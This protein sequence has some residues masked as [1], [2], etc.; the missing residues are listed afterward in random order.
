MKVCPN[1]K[2]SIRGDWTT[3]P[4]C[5][6]P[7]TNTT[8]EIKETTSVFLEFPLRFNRQQALKILFR[9]S[10]LLVLFYFIVQFIWPF[11]FFGLEYVIFGILI[12]WTSF[13]IFVYKRNNIAKT[14]LY[15]LLF[16]SLL[17]LYFDYTNGWVGWSITF[18]IPILSIS[19]ILAMFITMQV[20][21]LGVGDY[22]LYLQLASLIGIVPLL[23]LIMGWVHHP[24]PSILSVLFSLFMF[25]LLLLRYRKMM[26]RELQKRM[27]L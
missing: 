17:S 12:L 11:Q 16:I 1:C 13:V 6:V 10:L 22:I 3:C 25:T 26:I 2:A 7:L 18:V 14:I 19:S 24:L 4:I 27:H 23:L 15:F 9:V 20:T 8:S 5:Q 21:S